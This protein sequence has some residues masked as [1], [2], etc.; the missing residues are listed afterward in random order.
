MKRGIVDLWR[1]IPATIF[2]IVVAG[3]VRALMAYD[4]KHEPERVAAAATRQYE[5][6]AKLD[7]A[8]LTREQWSRA[9]AV[10]PRWP[11]SAAKLDRSI[12]VTGQE[13]GR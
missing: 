5:R 4:D 8:P 7:A 3:G 11:H 13:D 12:R 10:E 6:Q 9:Q 1:P 2:T